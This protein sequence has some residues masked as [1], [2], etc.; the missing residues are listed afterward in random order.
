M[1]DM[2]YYDREENLRLWQAMLPKDI[3]LADI[4]DAIYR[5]S[6]REFVRKLSDEATDSRSNR[7]YNY[8]KNS[9]DNEIIVF[10]QVARKISDERSARQSPWYYPTSRRASDGVTDDN[11][12]DLLHLCR[13]YEGERLR[14]RYDLQI[15]RALFALR[16]YAACIEHVDSAYAQVADS[17]LMK[18]MARRYAAGCLVR[19]GERDR[20]DSIYAREGDIF[21][22][23]DGQKGVRLMMDLNPDAPQLMEYIRDKAYSEEF[24]RPLVPMAEKLARSRQVRNKGDWNFLL[25]YVKLEFD[26]DVKA[27]HRYIDRA[28]SQNFSTGELKDMAGLYKMKLDAGAYGKVPSLAAFKTFEARMNPTDQDAKVWIRRCQNI[29]YEDLIPKLWERKDYATAL[30]LSEFAGSYANQ[31]EETDYDIYSWLGF[32]RY[33]PWNYKKSKYDYGSLTFQLMGSLTSGQLISAYNQMQADTPL[34]NFLR[35]YAHL[36]RDYVNELIGTLALREENYDRAINY[37]QRVSPEYLAQMNIV[38]Y[39][40]RDAFSVYPSRRSEWAYEDYEWSSD[41]VAAQHADN[42][43]NPT[44]KLEFARRMRAYRQQMR[45]GRT[46]DERGWARLMYAIGRRNSLEECWALTQYWRGCVH[47]FY[48]PDG[49]VQTYDYLDLDLQKQTEE[50]YDREVAAALAMLTSDETKAK[51][52]YLFGN[53]VTIIKRYPNTSTAQH[54]RTSCDHWRQWL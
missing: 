10:L 47:R 37:L 2:A 23:S 32:D 25:A 53:L 45:R 33:L 43:P 41:W 30:L 26:D 19:L 16:Q 24:M 52:E 22:I 51:A 14:T 17:D 50:I 18:R 36:D 8:L 44:G 4:E 27:A 7:F 5:D 11:L 49:G 54:V 40:S 20:A 13:Q 1:H 28:M 39:L 29:I 12:D 6:S 48:D 46:A 38:D 3:P 35:K 42:E 21:S 31:S 9:E 34:Y 15:T